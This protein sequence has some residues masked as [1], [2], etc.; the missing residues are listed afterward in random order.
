MAY[1][2]AATNCATTV[3]TTPASQDPTR[4]CQR[5][6]AASGRTS[7]TTAATG[8]VEFCGATAEPAQTDGTKHVTSAIA[9]GT[10]FELTKDIANS[11][12]VYGAVADAKVVNSLLFTTA[13][14]GCTVDLGVY[15][16]HHTPQRDWSRFFPTG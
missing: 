8:D 16:K 14:N 5:R 10:E 7:W 12:L 13:D 11:R 2:L 1:T 6:H 4:R 3:L 15:P 9:Q